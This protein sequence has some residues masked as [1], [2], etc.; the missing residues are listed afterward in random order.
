MNPTE[1]SRRELVFGLITPLGVDKDLVTKLLRQALKTADYDLRIVKISTSILEYAKD[2]LKIKDAPPLERKRLL[3]NVGDQLRREWNQ[4]RPRPQ[5]R[6]EIGAIIAVSGIHQLRKRF[7]EARRVAPREGQPLELVPLNNSAYLI[8]SLKHPDEI[9]QLRRIYGPAF[10]SIGVYAPPD[11]RRRVLKLDAVGAQEEGLAESLF[12]RDEADSKLGQRVGDAFFAADFIVD[13]TQSADQIR[14]ELTRLVRLIF[15]DVFET[16]RVDEYGMFLARAAQA[17]SG[18]LARQVGAAILRDDGS[19]IACGTNEVP[20]PISGGQYWPSDDALFNGRDMKY[21]MDPNSPIRDTSDYF[22]EEMIGTV[23]QALID[24]KVLN[25]TY[26]KMDPKARLD[27]LYYAADA[28]LKNT[29]IKDNIDYIRAVHAEASAIIDAARH[30][31][32]T[33]GSR[34][35]ATTFPCHECARHIIAAGIREVIYLEPYPK[36]G[37]RQLYRDSIVLDPTTPDA[38]RVTFRSFVGVSPSRYLEFFTLGQRERKT[39][40]G[41]L[42]TIDIKT[43]DPALPYYTPSPESVSQAERAPLSL[44]KEF[45]AHIYEIGGLNEQAS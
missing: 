24:G 37:T 20:R 9:D 43:I 2:S 33:G 16:P 19:V 38:K 45:S 14:G 17:R 39:K 21:K 11:E 3:M 8:D 28:P 18:S 6:G 30:G 23:I 27:A 1:L 4:F 7:N 25:T 35:L 15:G 29:R 22:R 31:V 10:V 13:G 34:M 12:S 40:N 5:Q 32:P 26:E 36:S 41:S 42:Q 44:F